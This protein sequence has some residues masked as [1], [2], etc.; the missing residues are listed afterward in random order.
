MMD[1]T[2]AQSNAN[3][4]IGATGS[5]GGATKPGAISDQIALLR[6][7]L[8]GLAETVTGLTKEQ[9]S[10]KLA[11]VQHVATDKAG[12]MTAAIRSNPMQSTAIAAGIGFVIG[13]LMTR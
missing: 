13:L 9:L 3:Q 8:S 6:N 11:D 12:E 1:R 5:S 2:S 10:D 7:E 4:P